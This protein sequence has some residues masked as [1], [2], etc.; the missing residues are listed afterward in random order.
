MLLEKI[1]KIEIEQLAT[2]KKVKKVVKEKQLKEK[3]VINN[4]ENKITESD[5]KEY[6]PK[7]DFDEKA[8]K[9]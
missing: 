9:K 3:Q 5:I 1:E 2:Q 6:I 4:R 8:D 7:S